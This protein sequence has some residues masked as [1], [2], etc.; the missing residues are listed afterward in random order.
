MVEA[1][2][3]DRRDAEDMADECTIE[4]EMSKQDQNGL[5]RDTDTLGKEAS[6]LR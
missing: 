4:E 3:E 1:L 6:Y 2:E 5:D